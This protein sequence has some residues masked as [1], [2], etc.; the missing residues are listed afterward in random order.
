[1]NEALERVHAASGWPLVQVADDIAI[2]AGV[3]PYGLLSESERWRADAAL[4]YAAALVSGCGLVLLDRFDVLDIPSRGQFLR[5]ALAMADCEVQTIAAGT[6]KAPPKYR[7]GLQ[8][9]W[10]TSSPA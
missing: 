6:L 7:D 5:L 4:A 10:L 8:V 3:R 9:L 2:I 1:L